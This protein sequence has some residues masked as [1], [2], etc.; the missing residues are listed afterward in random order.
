MIDAPEAI[1]HPGSRALLCYWEA[2]RGEASAP[3]RRQLDLDKIRPLVPSLF[4]LERH[5][6][7]GYVWRLAGTRL[8]QLWR[9]E[10]TGMTAFSG[11]SVREKHVAT[12]LCNGAV[13]WHQPFVLR[14]RLLT[15]LGHDIGAEM[16][17]LPLRSLSGS[18][19]HILG[20]TMTFRDIE[21]LE[22]DRIA[23]IELSAA[24]TIWS[25]PLPA[26]ASERLIRAEAQPAGLRIIAG[27]RAD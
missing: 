11:L 1:L 5:P 16:I 24:R 17:G 9:R 20:A 10:L 26:E 13:R 12:R 15:S 4:I 14:L 7:K 21:A 6:S 18:S 22:Y 2:I 25:E 3:L 8:C 27:G 19:T 23:A